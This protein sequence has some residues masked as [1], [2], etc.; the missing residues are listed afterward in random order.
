MQSEKTVEPELK[1]KAVVL[2]VQDVVVSTVTKFVP[3]A[4]K[5]IPNG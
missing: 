1:S 5:E 2:E 4:K 3:Q